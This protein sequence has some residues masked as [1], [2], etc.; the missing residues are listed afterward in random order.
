M[1]NNLLIWQGLF[2]IQIYTMVG[3][4][5][6]AMDHLEIVLSM[7]SEFSI[8]LIRTDPT[9]TLILDNPRFKKLIEKYS[10]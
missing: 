7:P 1:L 9:W 6:L 3:E 8:P 4:Y 2:R 5:D 10:L